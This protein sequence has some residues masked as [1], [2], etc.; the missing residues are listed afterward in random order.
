ME[1]PQGLVKTEF[2][3]KRSDGAED[4]IEKTRR[5][6]REGLQNSDGRRRGSREEERKTGRERESSSND[7]ERRHLIN[8]DH[9]GRPLDTRWNTMDVEKTG[10]SPGSGT[11]TG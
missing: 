6:N 9:Q 2:V 8:G 3:R 11:Q 4:K 10:V 5:K 7:S 1:P